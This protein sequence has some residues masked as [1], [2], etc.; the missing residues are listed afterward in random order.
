MLAKESSTTPV[1]SDGMVPAPFIILIEMIFFVLK[2]G[3]FNLDDFTRGWLAETSWLL[4]LIL[5]DYQLKF[6]DSDGVFKN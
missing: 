1:W 3:I 4:V 6:I 2:C 5:N